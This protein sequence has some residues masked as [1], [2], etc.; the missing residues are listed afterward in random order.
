[1]EYTE[2]DRGSTPKVK[3]E[4]LSNGKFHAKLKL[5]LTSY[6]SNKSIIGMGPFILGTLFCFFLVL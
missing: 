2:G 3:N 4:N 5:Q 6:K 1:M